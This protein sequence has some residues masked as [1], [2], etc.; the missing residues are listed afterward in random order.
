M[1]RIP[2]LRELLKVRGIQTMEFHLALSSPPNTTWESIV[3]DWQQFLA[4]LEVIKQPYSEAA[5]IRQYKK[6]YPPEKA[7]R[8]VFGKANVATRSERRLTSASETQAGVPQQ[9]GRADDQIAH[10]LNEGHGDTSPP[11]NNGQSS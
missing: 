4:A 3:P 6:D 10:G 11:K 5:L 9:D 7:K 1:V 2:G 8:T